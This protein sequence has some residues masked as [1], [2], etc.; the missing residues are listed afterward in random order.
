MPTAF[1]VPTGWAN[2]AVS[3]VGEV[4]LG[5]QR[6]PKF[7]RGENPT[8]YLRA[9]N[10]APAGL[11]LDDVLQMD[12]TPEERQVYQLEAG[13]VVLSEASGSPAHVG[14][15]AIWRGEIPGCC[16]QN[17]VI[18]FRPRAVSTEYAHL[19]FRYMA[20]SGAFAKAA[21]GVGIQH[22][23]A[24]RFSALPFPLPPAA[25]QDR[26]V[27]EAQVRLSASRNQRLTVEQ[28]LVR[29]E[30]MR[31]EIW[32][33]AVTGRLVVQHAED[34]P[35]EALIERLGPVPN[36]ARRLTA[37][38]EKETAL[39]KSQGRAPKETVRPLVEVLSEIGHALSVSELFTAAGYD[40]DSASDVERF[41]IALR[42]EL[43]Q[44]IEPVG[45]GSEN[46]LVDVRHAT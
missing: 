18:R 19:V 5:R 44:T 41:Y 40:R 6:A 26:I 37:T 42:E 23:G 43:G 20:D 24:A 22:L 16:F 28:S 4:R 11:D 3:E 14:R 10:I 8:P 34:E 46:V 12:F 17:T 31:R 13:D 30:T 2:P 1:D 35:A 9:A 38:P 7:M 39:Q 15:S 27:S 45:D 25:E 33:A 29:F 21:R 32:S 36:A